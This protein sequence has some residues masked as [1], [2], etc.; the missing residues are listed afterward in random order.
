MGGLLGMGGRLRP[1]LL[2]R[3]KLAREGSF[4]R[5]TAE[6]G[7]GGGG[8]WWWRPKRSRMVSTGVVTTLEVIPP[9]L[10]ARLA[11]NP[12]LCGC[13]CCCCSCC[14]WAPSPPSAL[15]EGV[16]DV[17]SFGRWKRLGVWRCSALL[18]SWVSLYSSCVGSLERSWYTSVGAVFSVQV[19]TDP[20]SYGPRNTC[21]RNTK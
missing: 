3:P 18:L 12:L 19:S 20:L 14:C 8:G 7:A 15:Q 16:G 21:W 6:V 11:K 10:E 13:C 17:A 9:K 5:T 2:D 1:R 4:R